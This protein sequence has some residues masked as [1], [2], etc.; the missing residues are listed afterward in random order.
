MP[1]ILL[2]YAVLAALN[3][4]GVALHQELLEWCTKPLLAPLLAA[5]LWRCTRR[6][7]PAVLAGLALATAGDVALLLPG[8]GAFVAG[9]ACFLGT[10]L[11]YITAFVQQGAVAHLRA[12][13][14]LCAA[15][16]AVWAA[17][18][19]ALLPHLGPLA[20]AVAPYSLALVTMAATAQV[21]GPGAAWG[22]AVFVASDLLIGLGAAG[23]EF[24]GRPVLVMATYALAQFLLVDAFTRTRPPRR[25]HHPAPEHAEGVPPGDRPRRAAPQNG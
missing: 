23:A 20:W 24:P 6:D 25:K 17:A 2:A 11:C 9:I 10:Q 18:N 21:R 15:C 16:L 1:P 7:H 13:P 19:A 5:Y 8:A 4:A 3:L 22:G 12:R 14:L